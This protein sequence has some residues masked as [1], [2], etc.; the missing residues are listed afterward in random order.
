MSLLLLFRSGWGTVAPGLNLTTM[1][2]ELLPAL[3]A[4]EYSD[5]VFWTEAEL[6]EFCDEAAK[7]L[8]RTVGCFVERDAS[9]TISAGTAGYAVPAR[10][11]S[12]IHASAGSA[13]LVAV[14]IGELEAFDDDWPNTEATPTPE[15]YTHTTTEQV[16][17]YP[18]PD[19]GTSTPL[20]LVFHR[21][22]ADISADSAIL[23]APAC[24]REYFHFSV[25]AAARGRESKGAMPE[26]AAFF[27][28]LVDLYEEAISAYWGNSQ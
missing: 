5:L 18:K 21:Y 15:R 24:L 19:T 4:V 3:G 20:A 12:T 23:T 25:L 27:G 8:A 17:L 16:T 10:H 14:S 28:Q 26:V 7:R 6:Y 13:G 11:I 9:T 1:L 2:G 22:P